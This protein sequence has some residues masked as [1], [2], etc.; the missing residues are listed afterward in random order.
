LSKDL[1]RI[2]LPQQLLVHMKSLREQL[3][4]PGVVE[5][6]ELRPSWPYRRVCFSTNGPLRSAAL[7]VYVIKAGSV[8]LVSFFQVASSSSPL[9]SQP[10]LLLKRLQGI[11]AGIAARPSMTPGEKLARSSRHLRFTVTRG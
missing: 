4:R 3:Q 7:I 6:R 11:C 5:P 1:S 9:A 8:T 2:E 10:V